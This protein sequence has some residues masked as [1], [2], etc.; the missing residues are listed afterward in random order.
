MRAHRLAAVAV[1]VVGVIGGVAVARATLTTTSVSAHGVTAVKFVSQAGRVT[2]T[3]PLPTSGW[4]NVPGAS[5]TLS[6]PA[7]TSAVLLA[8]FDAY[9]GCAAPGNGPPTCGLRV[10]VNGVAM[11][12]DDGADVLMGASSQPDLRSIERSSGVL[13]AGTYTVQVQAL[14][15]DPAYTQTNPLNLTNWS[16]TVERAKA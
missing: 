4:V 16:L 7:S 13:A 15:S 9:A 10:V 14:L 8:H 12:P 5:A 11:N 2:V 3:A 1:V 6:I